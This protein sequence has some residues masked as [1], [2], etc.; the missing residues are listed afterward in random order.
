MQAHLREDHFKMK[1][2][3]KTFDMCKMT[4]TLLSVYVSDSERA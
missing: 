1:E 2:L 3:Q 4:T